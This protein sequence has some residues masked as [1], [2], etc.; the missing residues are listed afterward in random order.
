M[1]A[2]QSGKSTYFSQDLLKGNFTF[3]S[4]ARNIHL[5]INNVHETIIS[6]GVLIN[7]NLFKEE[8]NHY[9]Q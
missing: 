7:Q 4:C 6:L 5:L 1:K 9:N 8:L 3:T 2:R